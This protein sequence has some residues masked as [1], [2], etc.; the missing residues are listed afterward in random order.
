MIIDFAD[1]KHVWRTS[2]FAFGQSAQR[3]GSFVIPDD[4]AQPLADVVLRGAARRDPI[5]NSLK[6][7]PGNEVDAGSLNAV[8]R[9]AGLVSTPT[10]RLDQGT[11][12]VLMKGEAQ[13]YAA[14][15]SHLMI[16]GP[17]HRNLVTTH[18]T[19]EAKWI[20]LDLGGYQGHRLHLEFG[21]VGQAP[22]SIF[23]VIQG[24]RPTAVPIVDAARSEKSNGVSDAIV[25]DALDAV[26]KPNMSQQQ[27]FVID[28]LLKHTDQLG[29]DPSF[30][31]Q[32]RAIVAKYH[33]RRATLAEKIQTESLT[34]IA[35]MDG[36]GVDE[37]VLNRGKYQS[38]GKPASRRLPVAF[39]LGKLDGG[40]GSGRLQ[41][42]QQL[43]DP[44]NP[45]TSRVIVNRIWHHLIGRGIVASVDNFG[46]LGS[47]PTHPELLD[48][49]AHQFVH[50]DQWSIKTMIKRILLSRT[51][52]MSSRPD[53]AEAEQQDPK[54]LLLHRMPV[55]RLDAEAIRD[56]LLAVSGRLDPK[57]YGQPVPVHLTE[58]VIGR[59][60]TQ[61]ERSAGR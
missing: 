48:H 18:K 29:V 59:G 11:I 57:L 33:Q 54:N 1:P 21:P 15:D 4:P 5:W 50:E 2:G 19:P 58:F 46:Y 30:R 6:L 8:G 31:E 3:V 60:Q 24:P 17:L 16:T 42:A 10:F 36:S 38:P 51:F 35:L 39:E 40:P 7:K 61:Q 49:L 25:S 14:I 28:W 23:K 26:A 27:A 52:A 37:R 32:Q 41:L 9:S 20:T 13:I 12:H 43:V 45:L 55:R 44:A 53:D 34:A 56:S 47:R 22:L